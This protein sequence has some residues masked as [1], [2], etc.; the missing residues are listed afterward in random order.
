MTFFFFLQKNK[1]IKNKYTRPLTLH[2]HI[3][4]NQIASQQNIL[5]LRYYL[6]NTTT[7]AVLF[8]FF[9]K[10]GISSVRYV[11]GDATRLLRGRLRSRPLT[12]AWIPWPVCSWECFVSAAWGSW[13]ASLRAGGTRSA[14][15]REPS[16]PPSPTRPSTRTGCRRCRS[17]RR[18]CLSGCS[19]CCQLCSRGGWSFFWTLQTTRGHCSVDGIV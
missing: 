6:N 9:F 8:F 11:F 13:R 17:R 10:L 18:R 3:I 15:C 14:A 7:F 5:H 2:S 16:R 12:I 19:P 4:L 1:Y